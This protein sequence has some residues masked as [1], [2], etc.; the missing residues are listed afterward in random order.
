[1]HTFILTDAQQVTLAVAGT[2]AAGNPKA[3]FGI[4]SWAS[5]DSAALTVTPS[6]D[7]FTALAVS[8]AAQPDGAAPVTVTASAFADAAMTI[9][10]SGTL[11]ISVIASP[12]TQLVITPGTP[13]PKPAA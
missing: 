9:A 8:V 4:P 5:G 2:D 7:G 3:V 11:S 6:A 13:E 10:I 12:A 1:M